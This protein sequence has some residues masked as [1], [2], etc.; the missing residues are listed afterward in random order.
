MLSGILRVFRFKSGISRKIIKSGLVLFS[1]CIVTSSIGAKFFDWFVPYISKTKSKRVGF[2]ENIYILNCPPEIDAMRIFSDNTKAIIKFLGCDLLARM[3][4]SD[5][6]NTR[7][8]NGVIKIS[9]IFRHNF[10]FFKVSNNLKMIYISDFIRGGLAVI[11]N[12]VSSSY[13]FPYFQKSQF[14]FYDNEMCSA[15]FLGKVFKIAILQPSSNGQAGSKNYQKYF[16]L[17]YFILRVISFVAAFFFARF[18]VAHKN[19]DMR[20]NKKFATFIGATIAM[21]FCL[22]FAYA[23]VSDNQ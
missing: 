18:I 15:V 12:Y 21:L 17:G 19:D 23:P 16:S 7:A 3:Y 10:G 2:I 14:G 4:F 9:R 11:S 20:D 6:A 22:L 8:I 5:I 1:I 13:L